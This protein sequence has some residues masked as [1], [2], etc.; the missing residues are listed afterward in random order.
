MPPNV[1]ITSLQLVTCH[2]AGGVRG[3]FVGSTEYHFEV[4]GGQLYNYHFQFQYE[5]F[6]SADIVP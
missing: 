3:A 4:A 6:E 1:A 2:P 5:R